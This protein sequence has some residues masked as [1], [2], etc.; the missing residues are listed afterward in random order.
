MTK[1][2]LELRDL[3]LDLAIVDGIFDKW[4]IQEEL[5]SGALNMKLIKSKNVELR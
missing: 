2:E 3:R 4:Y 1:A 5:L